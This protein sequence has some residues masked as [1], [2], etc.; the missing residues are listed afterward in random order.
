MFSILNHLEIVILC[1]PLALVLL[2]LALM[3]LLATKFWHK[4][5]VKALSITAVISICLSFILIEN[6]T[7][8]LHDAV[9]EDYIPF[10]I[11]L[12]TLYFLGHGIHIKLKSS[13]SSMANVSFLGV[14]SVFASL[15]GTTGA[16]MLFLR[17]FLEMNR[18]RKNKSHLVIFFIFLVSN[19]GGLL[20]PLGDPP[21]LIGYIHGV[22]FFWM[23][24]NLFSSWF[25]YVAICLLLLFIIDKII[26]RKEITKLNDKKFSVNITGW[27]NISLIIGAIVV[28][29]ANLKI[30]YSIFIKS[31]IL[32]VF[33]GISYVNSKSKQQEKID[34]TPFKEV[35]ITF[36]VIFVVIAPVL[37]I[38]STHT[39]SIQELI[40]NLSNGTH[41]SVVY[42]WLCGLTS[43]F[44]DNAPSYLLFF[45][46]AGGNANELMNVTPSILK[47]IS[48]S[49][50]VMGAMTYIGNA[51]NMM[52][53]SISKKHGINM[54]SFL[55][56][57][58]WSCLV[59]LPISFLMSFILQ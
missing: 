26:L 40:S 30:D 38:L 2:S 17:S 59:I 36:L 53:R 27:L 43:S 12:F 54:P 49:S 39:K 14:C 28:L 9:I 20:T 55:G 16:S 45:N 33:C 6:A 58:L 10:I 24:Q 3:P 52:V 51:P 22:D 19:I 37:F 8:V 13:S 57:M 15:I 23:S 11:T 44:L 48:I 56:Y 35:A 42:F 1:L 34:F 21:L 25:L 29:S 4:N 5:E 50:V 47:A 31:F 7:S 41:S 46:M 32:L 18:E